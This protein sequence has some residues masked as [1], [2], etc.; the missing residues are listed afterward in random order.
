MQSFGHMYIKTWSAALYP[1]SCR[2]DYVAP[3]TAWHN[4]NHSRNGTPSTRDTSS[5][6]G[7]RSMS[8][9]TG[10]IMFKVRGRACPGHMYWLTGNRPRLGLPR[11]GA[12]GARHCTDSASSSASSSV[13]VAWPQRLCTCNQGIWRWTSRLRALWTRRNGLRHLQPNESA[14]QQPL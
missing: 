1:L 7:V 2:T 12:P 11:L 10:S 14:T 4:H 3:L 9:P 8:A 5:L 6:Y 13:A